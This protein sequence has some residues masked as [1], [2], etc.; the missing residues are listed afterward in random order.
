MNGV[1]LT[2]LAV[3]VVC[4]APRIVIATT[5]LTFVAHCVG[6]LLLVELNDEDDD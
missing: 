2:C 5:A 4:R 3:E 6:W 1:I